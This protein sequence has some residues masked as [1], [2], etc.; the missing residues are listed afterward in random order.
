MTE[1]ELTWL[2]IHAEKS[3]VIAEIGSWRGRS[4]RAMA[5]NSTAVIFCIDPWIDD[6]IGFPGWWTQQE[7]PD[8]YKQK[9]W[10][11]SEFIKYNGEYIGTRIVPLR[12]FSAE[13]FDI[14]QPRGVR[15]DMVFIDGSHDYGHVVGDISM[16]RQLLKPGGI[17]CGHDYNEPTCPEVAPAVNSQFQH[18]HVEGTIWCAIP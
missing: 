4:T 7:S 14:L 3:S 18:L 12:M 16:Y 8:K 1:Q 15:F 11:W 9:D 10:L 5:D 2:A 13:A 17:L 6:S